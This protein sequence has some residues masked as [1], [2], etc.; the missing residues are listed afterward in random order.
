[1]TN[2]EIISLI[3]VS[4]S[5]IG[6][7]TSFIFSYKKAI[8]ERDQERES[9]IKNVYEIK[10]SIGS[11]KTNVDEIKEK[12]EK[13][14]DKMESDHE[15]LIEHEQKIRNLEKEVFYKGGTNK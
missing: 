6:V 12:V 15:K 14:D 9:N 5:F 10:N 8:K 1:M 11:I 13:I 3:A 2:G 7:L 4:L